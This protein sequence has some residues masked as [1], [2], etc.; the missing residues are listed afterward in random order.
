MIEEDSFSQEFS[1]VRHCG[2]EREEEEEEEGE[3]GEETYFEVIQ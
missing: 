1:G 3:E 2:S